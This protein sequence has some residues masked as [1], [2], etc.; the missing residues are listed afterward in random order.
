MTVVVE[1]LE[2]FSCFGVFESN[3]VLVAVDFFN[4]VKTTAWLPLETHLP[5]LFVIV[6][7][8]LDSRTF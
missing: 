6:S 8:D 3:A 1:F 5:L 2:D 7:C 4:K